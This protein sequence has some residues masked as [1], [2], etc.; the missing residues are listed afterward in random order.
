[1]GPTSCFA[2]SSRIFA[3]SSA[4]TGAAFHWRGLDEKI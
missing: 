4:F 2:R 3:A 1:M